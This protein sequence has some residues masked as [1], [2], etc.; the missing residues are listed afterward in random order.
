MTAQDAVRRWVD[1]WLRGMRDADP[2]VIATVYAPGADFR[3]HPF[4][5]AE[6]ARGY[7]ARVLAAGPVD[8]AAFEEPIVDGD[9][10]AVAYRIVAEGEEIRGVTLLRFAADGRVVEHRD[11]WASL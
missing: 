4:R 6:T 1:A 10:A 2:D 5:D 3:S 11:Y 9:R 8:E 7:A